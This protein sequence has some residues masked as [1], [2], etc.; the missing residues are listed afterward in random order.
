M[1]K[2]RKANL[3]KVGAFVLATSLLSAAVA[4]TLSRARFDES[5][6]YHATFADIS[7][8]TEGS[9]VRASGVD[10][11]RVKDLS[12][13]N[14]DSVR[15]TFTAQDAVPVTSTTRLRIR[16][17]NL[18]GDRYLDLARGSAS[19]GFPLADGGTIGPQNTTPALDLDVLFNGFKPLLQAISPTEVNDLTSSLLAV[20][21]GQAG[22]VSGLL[23]HVGS[24][25]HTL[26]DRDALIGDV[27][28]NL[29]TTLA[30][31]DDNRDSVEDLIDG[32]DR[33]TDGLAD[34]RKEITQSLGSINTL[35]GETTD[36]LVK[37]RPHLRDDVV[38]IG[39]VSRHVTADADY[40]NKSLEL[41][42]TVISKLGRVGAYGSFYNFYI[43]G[44]R[45]KFS[46]PGGEPTFTPFMLSKERRCQF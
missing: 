31:I 40:V 19:P 25:T 10:V 36:L 21:Q 17:A 8:L 1:R 35:A 41:F 44:I 15:V 30:T 24:L 3:I 16:Y 27:I 32:L 26:A 46:G 9:S 23:G 33:L 11:G 29:D 34:D 5:R 39:R 28:V 4:V 42:P 14:G 7:G 43:C 12:L 18:T 13:V 37:T 45:M 38:Q 20:T 22:A 2:H 6:T